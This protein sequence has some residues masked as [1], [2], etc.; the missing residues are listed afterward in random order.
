VTG[1]LLPDSPIAS[2]DEYLE[3]GGG[4]IGLQRAVQIGPTAT[5]EVV[6]RSGLRGRGGAGFPTG[7]KWDTVAGQDAGRRFVVVNGAEGEP[8][9]FKDR[10][11]MRR[12]PYQLVEGLIIAAFAV[13]AS[14]AYIACKTSFEAEL[15]GVARA[16]REMQE[17]GICHDCPVTI[18]GGPE[19]YLFGEEKALLEV[20]E[21][22]PPLP[23]LLPPY[24]VGLFAAVPDSG[25]EAGARR[26]SVDDANPTLVNNVETLSNVPHILAR[27]AD[28]F[29]SMGTNESPGTQVCTVVGDVVRPGVAEIEL[30]TPLADVITQ[31]G[32]GMAEGRAVK[33]VFSGVSNRVVTA[34]QLAVPLSYEGFQAIGSGMGAAGFIVYDDTACMVEVARMFSKFLYIESCGQ[35]P[36]C[37]LGSAEVT[38]R[39]T[40]IEAGAADDTTVPAIGGWLQRVTDG[41]R[42]YLPVQEREVVASILNAFTDEV[43]EHLDRGS[44]PRPRELPLPKLVDLAE[45]RVVYDE[46]Y[47][48]KQ[49]D[50]TYAASPG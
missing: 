31:V 46:H 28:W 48:R 16:A 43:A 32:G 27:G 14:E 8:G 13:G 44:C 6:R 4:S 37:K 15:E 45:G 50:W 40:R 18:V 7:R 49:P 10:T 30:G 38:D 24:E 12:N 29:R 3:R 21:G 26:G 42:C 9:T 33:A 5:I 22:R 11:L 20:I 41:N 47:Y 34:D 2:L 25:W 17:A 23:R 35:C 19:E 1:F 36:A 39:L